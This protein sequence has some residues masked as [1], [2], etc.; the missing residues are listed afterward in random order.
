VHS[1]AGS[2]RLAINW[3]HHTH[4]QQLQA[5]HQIQKDN[6]TLAAV[7]I[8]HMLLQQHKQIGMTQLVPQMNS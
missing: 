5:L 3:A 6:E 1:S 8:K 7:A 2:H 4:L